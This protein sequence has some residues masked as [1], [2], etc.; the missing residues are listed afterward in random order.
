MPLV[1]KEWWHSNTLNHPCTYTLYICNHT[2]KHTFLKKNN[3]IHIHAV[4]FARAVWKHE[5]RQH[6][7]WAITIACIPSDDI[8]AICERLINMRVNPLSHCPITLERII[9]TVRI[10]TS[11]IDS[12][13]PFCNYTQTPTLKSRPLNREHWKS[14]VHAPSNA[15]VSGSDLEIKS[16]LKVENE[17]RWRKRKSLAKRKKMYGVKKERPI[18]G[19]TAT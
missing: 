6:H 1:N 8:P 7:S 9:S 18:E 16:D 10:T 2:R 11:M 5:V 13:H 17:F 3:A 15:T 12:T 14:P 19:P 4:E